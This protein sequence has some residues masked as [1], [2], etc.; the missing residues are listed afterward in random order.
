MVEI[1][2]IGEPPTFIDEEGVVIN[3]ELTTSSYFLFGVGQKVRGFRVCVDYRQLNSIAKEMTE[4]FLFNHILI[5]NVKTA[6]SF[7]RLI[8]YL[9]IANTD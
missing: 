7:F 6:K 9:G 1:S 4:T 8:C 3:K 5:K 2:L